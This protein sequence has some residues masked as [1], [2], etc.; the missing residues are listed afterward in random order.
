MT[1][2]RQGLIAKLPPSERP[3]AWSR[4]LADVLSTRG[5]HVKPERG[6]GGVVR[7]SMSPETAEQLMQLITERA[8]KDPPTGKG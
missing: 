5:F 7:V 1:S 4:A 6:F 2:V 3:M 8:A